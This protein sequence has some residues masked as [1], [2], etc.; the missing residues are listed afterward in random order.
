MLFKPATKTKSKLRLALMG[1]SGSG[2]TY[3]AL[4]VAKHLGNKVAVIDSERGSAS[5]CADV[6]QFDFD[7]CDLENHSPE[8]Y[9][10][11]I[12]EAE[13]AGYDVIVIDSLSHAW[14]GKDG[15]LELVDKAAKRSQSGN[16]YTAWREVTPLHNSLIDAMLQSKCHIVATMRTKQE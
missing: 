9:I 8:V 15:A 12:K 6:L 14:T 5:K 10:K 13:N 11:C 16:S 7:T 2:K 4:T 3:T 1:P